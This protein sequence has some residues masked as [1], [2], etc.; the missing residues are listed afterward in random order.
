M[1][2]NIIRD[3]KWSPIKYTNRKAFNRVLQS[4]K[5]VFFVE[6]ETNQKQILTNEMI[7]TFTMISIIVIII[8][9]IYKM[10]CLSN[11]WSLAAYESYESINRYKSY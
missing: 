3:K 7:A 4:V 8:R 10:F 2:Y 11:V 9:I 6:R 1:N 5:S